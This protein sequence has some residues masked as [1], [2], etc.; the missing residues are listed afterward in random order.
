MTPERLT[1]TFAG[2]R[3]LSMKF[4]VACIQEVGLKGFQTS[5]AP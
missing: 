1:V 4:R 2:K 5:I 3:F